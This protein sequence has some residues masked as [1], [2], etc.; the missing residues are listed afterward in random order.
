MVYRDDFGKLA[1]QITRERDKRIFQVLKLG[2]S[3]GICEYDYNARALRNVY[4]Y[5]PV[6]LWDEIP[7][8]FPNFMQAVRFFKNNIENFL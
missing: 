3:Y 1:Y 7:D 4:I 2:S 8:V 5:N 6:L